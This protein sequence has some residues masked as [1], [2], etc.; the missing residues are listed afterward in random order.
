[1][2]VMTD[3]RWIAYPSPLWGGSHR[4]PLAAVIGSTP[5][6]SHRLWRSDGRGGGI[7]GRV[8]PTR[9][10]VRFALNV[11]PSPQ[12]GGWDASFL[13]LPGSLTPSKVANSTL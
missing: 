3:S 1:M 2:E 7:L 8:T 5:M 13:G 10:V 12:G 4:R 6:L 11:P 9:H